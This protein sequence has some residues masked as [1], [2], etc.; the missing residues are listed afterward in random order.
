[1]LRIALVAAILPVGLKVLVEKLGRIARRLD[2]YGSASS[3]RAIP[4]FRQHLSALC[5]DPGD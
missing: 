2:S 1:M 4:L 5:D 3:P